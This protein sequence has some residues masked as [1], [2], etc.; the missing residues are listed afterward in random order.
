MEKVDKDKGFEILNNM[1]KYYYSGETRSAEFRIEQLKKLKELIIKYEYEIIEAIRIDLGR[2]ELE[3]YEVEIGFLLNSISYM[4]KHLKRWMTPKKVKT[5]IHQFGARSYI[6]PQPYGLVLI[7]GPFNYPFSLLI[8]P[9]IGAI[10]AGNCVLLKP[11]EQTPNV[12]SLIKKIIEANFKREYIGVVEGGA[13]IIT[14]LIHMPFDY[15]FFTGSPSIG[16]II[17]KAASKNLIPV[18]LELGGKSPCI[19]DKDVNIK[20]ASKR[21][22]W[23]KFFNAGQ[24]CIAPDYVLIHESIHDEFL[25]ELK[26]TIKEFYGNDVFLSK[27]FGRIVNERH[28]KRIIAIIENDKDKILFGGKYNIEENYIEPTVIDKVTWKDE[29]M[30]EEIFGPVLPVMTFTDIDKV[31][32][33]INERPKPLAIYIFA[34]NKSVQRKVIENTSSGGACI[35]DTLSHFSNHHLPFGGVGNSGMGSYR[36]K[37]S[38]KTFSHMKG[39]L[40]KSTKINMKQIFPPYSNSNLNIIKKILR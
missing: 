2:H 14:P 28:T 10:A 24:T 22:A 1:K 18:T 20:I 9:M 35:N 3:T 12:S 37:M 6:K 23:G 15:I 33:M 40:N 17:M 29:S 7:I 4:M 8:E 19:V 36:G 27:S 38:F 16:K 11:S 5:P 39:V 34:E 25:E 13:E 31:I 30:K 32:T 21:I 26:K